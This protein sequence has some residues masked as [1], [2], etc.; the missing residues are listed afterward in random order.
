MQV[1]SWGDNEH[2]QQGNGST[3]S[4]KKPQLVA[5]LNDHHITSIAC[6]SSHSI[7]LTAGRPPSSVEFTPVSFQTAHD[8]LAISLSSSCGG[9]PAEDRA[10]SLADDSKRPS[11][12]KII[13][14]LQT[15]LKQQEALAHILTSLQIAYARDAI[16]NSLGGVASAAQKRSSEEGQVT[17]AEICASVPTS[18]HATL[19][20]SDLGSA[21]VG[22]MCGGEGAEEEEVLATGQEED[23]TNVLTVEDAR[24]MVDLL[25]LAVANR[26]GE[27]GKEN[28]AAVLT[29]MGKTNSTV[30]KTNVF[31]G[32]Y[33]T[34]T[35]AC[36]Q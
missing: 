22:G 3:M 19:S 28:L 10:Y 36:T 21:A 15:P 2:G 17:A 20:H 7:A 24:V 29:T 31:I 5:A 25:K 13:L 6:G 30:C 35:H 11:L 9:R 26:V 1:Y 23:F 4:N 16:V 34:D 14:S 32:S 18:P 12:I 27:K 8:P 33:Y